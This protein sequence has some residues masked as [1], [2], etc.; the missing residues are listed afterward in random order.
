MLARLDSRIHP[1]TRFVLSGRQLGAALIL[2]ALL[3]FVLPASA[4]RLVHAARLERARAAAEA[5]AGRLRS[6]DEILR[7]A[8]A[9]GAVLVGSGTSPRLQ[10]GPW[11]TAPFQA[12]DP[13]LPSARMEP[14]PWGN[15]YLVNTSG[16][17]RG[18]TVWVLSAGPNGIVDT[19]FDAPGGSQPAG[20]DV[21]A[22][23]R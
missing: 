23:I 5:L 6:Q 10:P 8:A 12:L 15:Q 9:A 2:I 7:T 17:V 21:G 3:A 20:D 22:R 13:L 1:T 11:R 4:A 16:L 18:A 19:P 14:D